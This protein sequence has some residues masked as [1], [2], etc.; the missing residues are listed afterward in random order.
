MLKRIHVHH[1]TRGMFIHEFCGSWMEHP[2]WR[3]Q[4]LIRSAQDLARIR[5]TDIKEVWIDT[6]KGLDVAPD[7]TAHSREQVNAQI[8]SDLA[9]LAAEPELELGPAAQEADATDEM[10]RASGICAS[11]KQA[12]VAMFREARMG[13]AIDIAHAG[14]VVQQI[15][16]SIDRSPHALI[17]LARLKTANEYTYMHSVAVAALMVA[18]ARQ[19]RLDADTT[20]MAGLAGLLHDLG[21]AK[22]SQAILNKPGRLTEE[23]FEIMRGHPLVGH[24]M[25][26]G[27]GLAPEVL[28][29]CL[30]HHEK[31]DGTGY[32]DHQR[33]EDIGLLARMNA[34]CDVYDAVTSNRPY[35]D[36]WDPSAALQRM[37]E[38]TP[39]HFDNRVFQA[40]VRSLGIYPVGS[41]VRLRSQRIGVVVAQSPGTLLAPQVK[42]FYALASD[43]RLAPVVVDL[44]APGCTDAVVAR[45]DPAQWKFPD[46]DQLWSGQTP[47][48][49]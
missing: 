42:V 15:S 16:G 46:L 35:K 34:V 2:F 28:D 44:S 8:D 7:T 26:F 10:Q 41:L 23:E 17:S 4:F 11:A 25:L 6:S 39:S 13:R 12:V 27:S 9:Q 22:I 19:L 18:L 14:A 45:A 49:R 40:F 24:T 21:K 3:S 47:T 37:A 43:A 5:A 32:P 20:R 31:M 36:G 30:H 1:L 33:G 29:A 38:W 48:G